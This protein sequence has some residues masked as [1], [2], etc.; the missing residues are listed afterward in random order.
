MG[1][2]YRARDPKLDREIALKVLS[3]ELSSS[4]E[5]LRRFEYEARAASALNHPNIVSIYDVGRDDNHAYIAME[6]VQ[7]HDLRDLTA[8]GPM[9]LKQLLRI[10]AKLADGLGAAHER[11]IVHR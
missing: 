4:N 2:V 7:G 10:A 8:D 6:L 9:S 11:G 1:E 5:H 3:T